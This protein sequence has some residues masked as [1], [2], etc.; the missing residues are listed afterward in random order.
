MIKIVNPYNK[1][2]LKQTSN[3]YVDE[4]DNFFPI[5]NGAIRIVHQPN[6]SDSFGFQWNQFRKTQIDR[7]IEGLELSITTDR[8]RRI[9]LLGTSS[10][11]APRSSR[12]V[13]V[14]GPFLLTIQ[15]AGR[16]C[17]PPL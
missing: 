11:K 6:Y 9:V 3:G 14:A 12:R 13:R 1:K 5:V 15:G 10:S 7:E 4:D 17:S 2:E 16:R 8:C